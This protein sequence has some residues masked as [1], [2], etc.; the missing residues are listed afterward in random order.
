MFFLFKIRYQEILQWRER[1]NDPQLYHSF[2][3]VLYS[4]ILATYGPTYN[5]FPKK[6]NKNQKG[7]LKQ[8]KNRGRLRTRVRVRS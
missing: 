6:R 1:Y 2:V 3:Q 8:N 4:F 7:K 5:H